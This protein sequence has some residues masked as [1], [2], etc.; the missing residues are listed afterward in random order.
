MAKIKELVIKL[1]SLLPDGFKLTRIEDRSAYLHLQLEDERERRKVDII[2]PFED[3]IN[4]TVISEL[5]I[6]EESFKL[7]NGIVQ[8]LKVR[9][10]ISSE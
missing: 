2:K 9:T 4:I 3:K 8:R 10:L 6:S 1:Q 7:I 5:M